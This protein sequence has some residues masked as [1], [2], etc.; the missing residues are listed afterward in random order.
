MCN[1]LMN[2]EL[3][4]VEIYFE[5]KPEKNVLELMKGNGYRWNVKKSCWYAKQNDN[6]L[7]IAEK[8]KGEKIENNIVNSIE[9]KSNSKDID[10]WSLTRYEK[11]DRDI[12][13]DKKVIASELRK[14]FKTRFPFVK[15]SIR[16][17]GNSIITEIKSSPFEKDS[18]YLKAI[19]EYCIKYTSDYNYDNSDIMSDYYDVNFY[20]GHFDIDY[21]YIQTEVNNNILNSMRKF[22]E[23]LLKEEERIKAE[24][25][26][27]QLEYE[28]QVAEN[29]KKYIERKKQEQSQTQYINNN[30]EVVE[31]NENDQYIIKKVHFGRLNKQNDIEDYEKQISKGDFY[32]EDVKIT[33]EIYFKDK[34]S[35]DYFKH[36]LLSDFDFIKGTGGS[37]TD[38]ERIDTI[39]D[40]YKMTN[41]E[42]QTVNWITLG[43]AIYYNDNLEFI[44]NAEGYS[45][46]RYVGLI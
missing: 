46:S 6:T 36:M 45:Y 34:V 9:K 38:D 26:K 43:V 3:N 17:K 13:Y 11:V 28:K 35:L 33:K 42:Q 16:T 20:G 29:E 15:F 41:E 24:E 10:L 31:L 1:V 22:D 23:E 40:Y 44:V 12:I 19:Q 4:G 32:N 30:I 39:Q 8:I 7:E 18:V 37:Y 2:N 27:R 5:S 21:D 14:H 25:E